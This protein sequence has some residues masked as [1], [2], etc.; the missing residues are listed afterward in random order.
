MV[1]ALCGRAWDPFTSPGELTVDLRQRLPLPGA[2][3]GGPDPM[4]N[5]DRRLA[6]TRKHRGR[7]TAAQ[8]D[9]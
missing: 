7:Q 6:G 9:T 4:R 3:A 5:G 1:M 8:K 2:P